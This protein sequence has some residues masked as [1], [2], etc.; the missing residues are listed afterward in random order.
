M[1]WMVRHLLLPLHA[2]PLLLVVTFSFGSLIAWKAGFAGIPLA[3]VLISWF[4]KYC[5]VLLDSIVAGEDEP[6]VLS[7]EMVN[8]VDEQRPLMT[9]LLIGAECAG[10]SALEQHLGTRAA[11]PALVVVA[12]ALPASIAVMGVTGNPF[13]AMWPPAL[14]D[15]VRALRRDYV[16]LNLLILAFVGVAY[17]MG[18]HEVSVGTASFV[19]QMLLL[20]VFSLVG[21]AVFEHRLELGI[22]S[23]TR[24]ERFAERDAR[25]HQSER[26]RML[27]H[28]YSSFRVRKPLE[29]WQ[30]I[31]AWLR[32]HAQGEMQAV[33]YRA[34]LETT[35]KWD[36]VRAADRLANDFAALLLAR[37][38]SGE[39]L[40][41]IEER[42]RANPLFRPAPPTLA[43][44]MAELAGAAGKRSLQRQITAIGNGNA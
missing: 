30:E 11:V 36:D 7:V 35:S 13:R 27:D 43:V 33:E 28:A 40:Q 34:L 44:R 38:A 12:L 32:Q 4:F 5:F 1:R 37:R 19:G 39:A 9:A 29:G 14:I 23:R 16:V 10:V 6:P 20:I 18:V 15:V 17:W 2:T 24:A 21:G 25:E 8:P 31:E 3:V 22:E 41:V 26:H 42:L